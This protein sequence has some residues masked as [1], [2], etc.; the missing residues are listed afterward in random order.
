MIERAYNYVFHYEILEL[1]ED[2]A[3]KYK[4]KIGG[5]PSELELLVSKNIL[6]EI[7]KDPL[8]FEFI[9]TETGRATIK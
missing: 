1:L 3:Q 5:Y 2:A 9:I 6:K 7:P 4:E 8:G